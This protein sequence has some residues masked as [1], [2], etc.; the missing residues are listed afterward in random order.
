[1]DNKK[2]AQV[3]EEMANILEIKDADFFRVN[4]YRKASINIFNLAIDLRDMV[5]KNPHDIPKL[6]GIGKHLA[7]KI[8]ELVRVGRCKE[9]E[10]M[11]K[12]VPAGLL[13]MLDIRTLGPK[14]VKLLYSK[15]G[16]KGVK[17]LKKAAIEGKIRELEGMG[18]KS[19]KEILKAISEYSQFSKERALIN[20]AMQE[21]SHIILYMKK[22]K[23]LKNIEFAGSLR[24]KKETIGDI[25]ILVT[26][27]GSKKT[28]TEIMEHFVSYDEVL[29]VTAKG[30]T[31]SS[32]ILESGMQVDLRVVADESFG[33]A[34]HYFT[35]SKAHNIRVRNL[36]KRKG[37][38]VS[39]YGVFKGK[40][41]IA[42]KSEEEVFKSVGLPYIIP[43]I[44]RNEGEVEYG[45]KHKKFPKFVE[46]SDIKGDLHTHSNHSDGKHTIL[47]MARFFI[48]LGY[49]YFAVSDHSSVLGVTAGMGKKDIKKQWKE[50]DRL[51]KKL[52]KKIKILK[53][54]EVD[55][56][57][58]GSLDFSDEVLKE[59][60]TVII[61][62]H[63]YQRLPEKEQTKRLLAAIENPY[64]TILAH[65]SGRLINKRAPME[66]DVDKIIDACVHN[67]VALEI[68]SNPLRLD[69]ADRYVKRAKEKGAKFV[70]STDAHTLEQ[71]KFMEYGISVA[72]RGVA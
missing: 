12:S 37:L 62:A 22:C 38:K 61:G 33:A 35:G 49:S 5:D 4:A 28:N 18:E 44:R 8:I 54:A 10:K 31:K 48:K 52:A 58:D 56:L 3:F 26:V 70:I 39:E 17:E 41:Q 40:K 15:L 51:N 65:P 20:E 53:S 6:P 69:F 67:S 9:H 47:E 13:E 14:K 36:A 63:L 64:S 59:L 25:D 19:E 57:K 29:N 24:R 27:K 46:L 34:L 30:D 71:T 16:I 55:I 66:F 32:V 7:D 1:M 42:G 50:I 21:A 60:D 11:K 43:E 72:R 68:N 23:N 2:I 45:L